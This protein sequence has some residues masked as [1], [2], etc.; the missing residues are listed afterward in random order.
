MA[1]QLVEL[2][3]ALL[4]TKTFLNE[5]QPKWLHWTSGAVAVLLLVDP[6]V[7]LLNWVRHLVPLS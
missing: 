2:G 3:L 1:T 7:A 5:K 6:V 4:L